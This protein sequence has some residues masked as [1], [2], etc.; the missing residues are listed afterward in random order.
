MKSSSRSLGVSSTFV[1]FSLLVLII[2]CASPKSGS[3]QTLATFTVQ[4]QSLLDVVPI[5]TDKTTALDRLKAAGVEG[6]VSRVSE[7]I[8]YCDLWRREN[9]DVWPM[10]VA[11]LFDS[12]DKVYRVQSSV[13]ETDEGSSSDAPAQAQNW[14]E[15]SSSS[16]ED[17][18]IREDDTRS[19]FAT[20]SG[21][22]E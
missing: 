15:G 6:N 4:R 13:G 7:K 22:P 18:T 14:P 12:Q 2:G 8:F 17:Q 10:N 19:P 21:W 20:D 1:S 9:G 5:G 3:L 16:W 11:I